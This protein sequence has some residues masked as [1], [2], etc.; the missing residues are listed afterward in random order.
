MEG[1]TNEVQEQ[2]NFWNGTL[3][4]AKE[5]SSLKPVSKDVKMQIADIQVFDV[6]KENNPK[7]W[8]QIK[9]SFKLVDGVDVAGEIKYRGAIMYESF[10][11]FANPEVYDMSKPF[12]KSGAFLVPIK[13]LV[14][15]TEIDS[16]KLIE[17]G[18]SDESIA[19]LVEQLKDKQVLG[20]ILQTKETSKNP[21]TGKYEPT[22]ELKNE[23]KNFKKLPDTAL[24]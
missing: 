17:G 9:I 15:A 4:D 21:E 1:L 11:Y 2:T 10:V 7:N 16:P 5:M 20:S 6:D 24:V 23:I 3:T 13:Q 18:L 14:L 8:K 12:Y 22:G 19:I